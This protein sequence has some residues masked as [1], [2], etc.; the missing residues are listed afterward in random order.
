MGISVIFR[1][2][3]RRAVVKNRLRLIVF[4]PILPHIHIRGGRGGRY[5]VYLMLT[6]SI[7]NI[8]PNTVIDL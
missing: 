1:L 6:Y 5:T 3:F 7:M 4:V 8:I 2:L